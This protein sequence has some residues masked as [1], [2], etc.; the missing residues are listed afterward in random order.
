MTFKSQANGYELDPEVS[1]EPWKVFELMRVMVKAEL[2][3]LTL[4]K[5]DYHVDTG[6]VDT[7]CMDTQE[8]LGPLSVGRGQ[9]LSCVDGFGR[10]RGRYW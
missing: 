5:T 10:R 9:G 8:G 2:G 6:G 4:E 7:G 3:R 1:R